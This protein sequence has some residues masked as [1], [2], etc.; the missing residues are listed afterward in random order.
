MRP[1][2]G[3]AIGFIFAMIVVA[4]S[5]RGSVGGRGTPS[6][7]PED[8]SWLMRN[9]ITAL[10]TQIR[11]W[12]KSKGIGFSHCIS[13][14]EAKRVCPEGHAVPNTCSEVCSLAEAIC[15]NADAICGL[16]DDLTKMLGRR[17]QYAQ[18]KCT[19]AKASCREAKQNCCEKCPKE[20]P[21]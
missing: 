3:V 15:D 8:P 13:L 11:D 18:N 9:D 21:P 4:C 5:A 14:G 2:L 12:A 16:A 20:S 17:D 6:P 10:W 19:N 7:R 1:A